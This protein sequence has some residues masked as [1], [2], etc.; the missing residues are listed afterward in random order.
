[1]NEADY[2]GI[3]TFFQCQISGIEDLSG[4]VDVAAIGFPF[5]GGSTNKPGARYGPESLRKATSRLSRD[6]SESEP[7]YNFATDRIAAYNSLE[8][9]DCGDVTVVP[10]DIEE[11][12]Q[13]VRHAVSKINL[14]TLPVILGGD[15]SITF[16]AFC[17]R[18]EVAESNVGLIQIDAHTDTWGVDE[19][20]GEY[21]HGSPM[22]HI[23][24]S[25]YGSYDSHAVV[26]VRG[27]TDE[28][29]LE[30]VEKQD[31]HVETTE[32]VKQKGMRECIG[33][34]IDHV[35]EQTDHIYLT[36]DIDVVDPAFA[37]G[38]GTPVPGGIDSS[39]FLKAADLLGECE[40]I[41]AIDLMEV[42]PNLDPADTT[43]LLG[44]TFL[45]RFIQ[46]FYYEQVTD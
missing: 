43:S 33:S 6:L 30:I 17:G 5:D 37:P 7:T 31:L 21:Y 9:R 34:A 42:A 13:N 23:A 29:F 39:S 28:K 44:A 14:D 40:N 45:S 19:L 22:Y 20:Y 35:S 11:T 36:V 16:P 27:H 1:M 26:G 24:D 12:F 18:A 38:T 15:H 8:I 2:S 32:D 25:D 46:S 41:C 3:N 10:N 4:V